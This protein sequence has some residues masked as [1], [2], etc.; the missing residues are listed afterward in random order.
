M[1][2]HLSLAAQAHMKAFH[3]C[4]KVGGDNLGLKEAHIHVEQLLHQ[5]Q[6]K[7]G[8]PNHNH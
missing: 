4:Q 1:V 7:M 3:P 2:K 8:H 5:E 6:A